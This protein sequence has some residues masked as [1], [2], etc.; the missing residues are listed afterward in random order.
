RDCRG[1]GDPVIDAASG[2]CRRCARR[3]REPRRTRDDYTALYE[4][5]RQETGTP[6]QYADWSASGPR[7]NKWHREYP[8]W[9]SGAQVVAVFGSWSRF[10]AAAQGRRY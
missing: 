4:R 10:V 8:R 7:D 3:A 6:P 2:L 9:A 5:W 1:C